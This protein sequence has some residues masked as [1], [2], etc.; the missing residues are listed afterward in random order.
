MQKQSLVLAILGAMSVYGT[1]VLAGEVTIYGVAD[2][3]LNYS[4][5]KTGVANAKDKVAMKSGQESGSRLGIRGSEDLSP[6][7][8]A[9]FVL[10]TGFDLDNGRLGQNDRLFGREANLF[11]LTPYGELSLGRVGGIGGGD[12]SYGL[13]SNINPFGTSWGDYATNISNFMVSATRM[14]NTITYLTPAWDGLQFSAQYS[15]KAASHADDL[16]YT[17]GEEGKSSANRYMALGVSYTNGPWQLIATIDSMDY[18]NT[19]P[20]GEDNSIVATIGGSYDFACVKTYVGMQYFDK[21]VMS[22]ISGSRDIAF[23]EVSNVPLEGY[24]VTIGADMPMA[25]GTVKVAAGWLDAEEVDHRDHS[26]DRYGATIGYEYHLSQ[27]TNFYTAASYMKTTYDF[28]EKTDQKA[29]EVLAG[30]RHIF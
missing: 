1:V 8:R 14:D 24:G 17:P 25:S 30:I 19:L 13:L 11:V 22:L 23:A 5:V 29:T 28:G 6:D 16:A 10:E 9:G 18:A 12:G 15:L 21:A 7:V 4:H 26:F 20:Y 27:R 2:V 3:G